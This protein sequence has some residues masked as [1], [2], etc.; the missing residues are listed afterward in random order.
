MIASDA[1]YS[2]SRVVGSH[3]VVDGES[4]GSKENLPWICQLEYNSGL[5]KQRLMG[6]LFIYKYRWKYVLGCVLCKWQMETLNNYTV[7]LEKK[8]KHNIWF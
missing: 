1:I 2:L 4:T 8:T 5:K 7:W 6:F 3:S